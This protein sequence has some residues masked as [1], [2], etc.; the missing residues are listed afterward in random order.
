MYNNDAYSSQ[1]NASMQA[2]LSTYIAKVFGTMFLG[3]LVTAV[4]AIFTA[5]N[6]SMM[7]FVFGS[8]LFFVFIIAELGLVIALSAGIRKMSYGV[9]QL[10]FYLYAIVNGVTLASIFYVY[11]LGTIGLAFFTAAISF[12]VMAVYGAITKKDLTKIGNILFMA[13][14]GIIVA[15]IINLFMGNETF[16]LLISF[17]AVAIFVGLVAYDTQKLKSYYYISSGDYQMQ[18]KIA[19]MGAL[20]L[21]LDFINIFLYL[22]RIFASKKD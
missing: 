4:A 13:L 10:M 15:S 22:L 12:G 11:E 21:Y 9:T 18:R 8:N 5:T 17:A 16:D 1:G 7:E 19:V 3:L 14:I 2:G 20:S 6:E